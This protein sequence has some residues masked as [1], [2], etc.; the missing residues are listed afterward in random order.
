MVLEYDTE[1]GAFYVRVTDRPIAR[2][3]EISAFVNVDLDAEGNVVGLK[4]LCPPAAVSVE[5]R[6]LFGDRYPAGVEALT[7]VER[8]TQL[9]A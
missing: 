7:E 5:A 6:A 4:L 9:S 3:A 8:L 2:T 1:A